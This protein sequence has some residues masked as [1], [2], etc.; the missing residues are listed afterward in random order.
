MSFEHTARSHAGSGLRLF[1]SKYLTQIISSVYAALCFFYG[2][3]SYADL[4]GANFLPKWLTDFMSAYPRQI[5]IGFVIISVVTIVVLFV[6]EY[7][8][9]IRMEREED[10]ALLKFME[11]FADRWEFMRRNSATTISE[12]SF[13]EYY[14]TVDYQSR[15]VLSDIA[16][17][18]SERC[19]GKNIEACVKMVEPHSL[20]TMLQ[21]G[22][23]NDCQVFT[24]VRGGTYSD[25]RREKEIARLK[26][27]YFQQENLE[28]P[29][30]PE[31]IGL[32]SDFYTMFKANQSIETC[33]SPSAKGFACHDMLRYTTRI[34][35]FNAGGKSIFQTYRPYRTTSG[36]WWKKYNSTVCIPIRIRIADLHPGLKKCVKDSG[37]T[38]RYLIV[39][40]LC[41]DHDKHLP[42]RLVKD[43]EKYT[44]RFAEIIQKY[45]HEVA[46]IGLTVSKPEGLP[47]ARA[48]EAKITRRSGTL[49]NFVLVV[50][51]NLLGMFSK[52]AARK[53]QKYALGCY[54]NV[55]PDP[56]D[57]NDPFYKFVK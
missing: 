46:E 4:T 13:K 12:R 55:T 23:L 44:I 10:A 50:L 38:G 11:H 41:V 45:F 57:E 29:F 43:L 34:D 14:R 49:C 47:S 8:K 51:I 26:E 56:M 7:L 3:G 33:D 6:I 2:I 37:W 20:R 1:L 21:T 16:T 5:M 48:N 35:R 52:K 36:E 53:L 17:F 40:F 31:S 42:K 9:Y 32:I 30:R 19:D 25:E 54:S 18:F 22:D 39:A 28:H 15:I 27:E 24:L